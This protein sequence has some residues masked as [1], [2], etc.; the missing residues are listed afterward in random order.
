MKMCAFLEAQAERRS[1]AYGLSDLMRRAFG[2]FVQGAQ[3]IRRSGLKNT[4]FFPGYLFG[5]GAQYLGVFK[6][7]GC[8]GRSQGIAYNIGG[9]P[10][11]AEPDLENGDFNAGLGEGEEG[12]NGDDFEKGEG[13]IQSFAI[14]GDFKSVVKGL[15]ADIFA[16]DA[17][18]VAELAELG[19]GVEARAESGVSGDGFHHGGDAAFA[20]GAGDMN[21]MES[22]FG[23]AQL[24]E[25]VLYGLYAGVYAEEGSFA[26]PL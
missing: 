19:R 13:L 2:P 14:E 24:L 8:N 7:D 4:G 11:A 5:G 18:A 20:I 26:Q 21:A 3:H 10:A 17:N 1:S 16:I 15:G 23:V 9:V 12:R 6:R 25:G 22:A